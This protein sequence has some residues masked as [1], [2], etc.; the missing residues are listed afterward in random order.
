[1]LV[2][3]NCFLSIKQAH[4]SGTEELKK[5]QKEFK[6]IKRNANKVAN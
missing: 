4:F 6:T 1:M 3:E 2:Q 5:E